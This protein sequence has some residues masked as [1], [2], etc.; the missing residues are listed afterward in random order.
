MEFLLPGFP[1]S[2][3]GGTLKS[4]L[5]CTIMAYYE[6]TK[7]SSDCFVFTLLDAIS[8]LNISQTCEILKET[9]LKI[10]RYSG[11]CAIHIKYSRAT[12][13]SAPQI[14]S[15]CLKGTPRLGPKKCYNLAV[16]RESQGNEC[17]P[18]QPQETSA[19]CILS[20]IHHQC[21]ILIYSS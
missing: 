13:I 18:S 3:L 21:N 6:I 9:P 7:K 17:I 1:K 5:P 15:S 19:H 2:F 16:E 12:C 11:Y 14:I 20:G 4:F 10:K 8:L